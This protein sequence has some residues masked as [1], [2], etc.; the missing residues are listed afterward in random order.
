MT[1]RHGEG[2]KKNNQS[3]LVKAKG[4]FGDRMTDTNFIA[5]RRYQ[6]IN[7]GAGIWEMNEKNKGN[8]KAV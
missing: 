3:S 8:S 1:L 7:L 6:Y 4:Y 2:A 5:D